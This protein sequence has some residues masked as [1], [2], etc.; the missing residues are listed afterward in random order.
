M[1]A[2]EKIRQA[3]QSGNMIQLPMKLSFA[4]NERAFL[5]IVSADDATEGT[6]IGTLASTA[7][8]R[9]VE[10]WQGL[11][12]DIFQ[13]KVRQLFGIGAE[14]PLDWCVGERLE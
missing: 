12:A 10:L 6:L 14:T 13:E 4:R 9:H 3:E 1:D 2:G 5:A 7:S 11:M 8:V